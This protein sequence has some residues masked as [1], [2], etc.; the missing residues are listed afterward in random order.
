VIGGWSWSLAG[1]AFNV[2]FRDNHYGVAVDLSER[3]DAAQNFYVS[4]EAK[5]G[6]LRQEVEYGLTEL[7]KRTSVK[8][9]WVGA[10]VKSLE[11]LL[12][13]FERKSELAGIEQ[14]DDLVGGRIVTLFRADLQTLEG[15]LS[16]VFHVVRTE[17]KIEEAK[18]DT[19]GYMSVHFVCQL[20]RS[21]S[22]L[23][24]EGLMDFK[25]EIQFR[26]LL[27]D[28]WANVSHYID[29][30]GAGS[31]PNELRRDFYALSALFYVADSSFEN[32]QRESLK[33]QELAV[34]AVKSSKPQ[35]QIALNA[36]T[37][38]AFLRERFPDR[39]LSKPFEYSVLTDELISYADYSSIA[40]LQSALSRYLSEVEIEE[41][42]NPPSPTYE[43]DESIPFDFRY[44]DVGIMRRVALKD[45]DSYALSRQ[46]FKFESAEFDADDDLDPRF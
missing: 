21:S 3:K 43:D 2:R 15:S 7:V 42:K 19:F 33:S 38:R 25:F 30:K 35:D 6:L 29:Y 41:E 32:F 40:D 12:G 46:V 5:L 24:Y 20:L 39:T 36:D 8:S 14:I 45:S 13:K 27:M 22:G 16:E 4:N 44:S 37:M 10:R 17:N 11:S 23:R 26:T 31:L 9:H 1:V 28:A 18:V 34:A